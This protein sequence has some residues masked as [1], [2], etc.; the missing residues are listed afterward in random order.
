[1]LKG[2]VQPVRVVLRALSLLQLH[3]GQSASAV[4]AH[5]RLS[6]KAVRE[7]GRRYQ[8]A[9]WERAGSVRRMISRAPGPYLG[10]R[11]RNGSKSSRWYARIPP[12][13]FA[14][15]TVRLIA[16]EAVKRKLVPALGR[17]TIRILLQHDDL[18]PWR[19]KNGFF[20]VLRG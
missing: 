20:A 11:P 4:A 12:Q 7:I 3:D 1:M 2:G 16:E 17:E 18:Q 10:S 19:E 14:R 8:D 5:V 9:G 6:S 13:G 15:W